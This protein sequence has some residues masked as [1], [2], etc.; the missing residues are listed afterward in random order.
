[1]KKKLVLLIG[2]L[3]IT[4]CSTKGTLKNIQ[5]DNIEYSNAFNIY[6]MTPGNNGIY[7]LNVRCDALYFYNEENNSNTKLTNTR[8]VDDKPSTDVNS[9]FKNYEETM[10]NHEIIYYDDH[11][12]AIFTRLSIDG[13]FSYSLK[14]LDRK[15]ENLETLIDFDD[16]PL[17]FKIDSGRVYVLFGDTNLYINV[18]DSKFNKI[19]TL[20]FDD[21]W[22]QYGFYFKNG[23]LI[24]PESAFMI[25][26][27][28]NFNIDYRIINGP[29]GPDSS[30]EKTKVTSSITIDGE[31]HTFEGK[32]VMYASDNYFYVTN[33]EGTQTYEKYDFDGNLVST[34]IPRDSLNSDRDVSTLFWYSDFSILL[35]VTNERYVYGYSV[36][37][38][39]FSLFVCDFETSECRYLND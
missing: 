2:L 6:P 39:D 14:R 5:T 11:L 16:Y 12:Y 15:G 36:K 1:M 21:S 31:Q 24:I 8:Y 9:N 22:N 19:E 7:Y 32:L 29:N 4:S 13:S 25:E 26:T 10:T 37:E 28:D 3:M 20:E 23:E 17:R 33:L 38:E 27:G 35:R 30:V 34:V 18:Y